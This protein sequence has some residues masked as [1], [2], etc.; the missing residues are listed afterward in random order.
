MWVWWSG[1]LVA[2]LLNSAG[3]HGH[4]HTRKPVQTHVHTPTEIPC[5]HTHTHVSCIHVYMQTQTHTQSVSGCQWDQSGPVLWL[6]GSGWE[7]RAGVGAV[8]HKPY[9][10]SEHMEEKFFL[11]FFL[12]HTLFLVFDSKELVPLCLI[13]RTHINQHLSTCTLQFHSCR[14]ALILTDRLHI[15]SFVSNSTS[16]F[17]V[18]F[19]HL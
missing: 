6:V 19:S 9:Q 1:T 5:T 4:T 8:C 11:L 16:T 7:R 14:T 3:G 2:R 18:S 12:I 17:L 10:T 13:M 15:R